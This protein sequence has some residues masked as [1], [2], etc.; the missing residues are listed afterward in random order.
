MPAKNDAATVAG[1]AGIAVAAEIKRNQVKIRI[2]FAG[3][4]REATVDIDSATG[5][6]VQMN[7]PM[8]PED[9]ALVTAIVK[10]V[11]DAK[12]TYPRAT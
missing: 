6:K 10:L 3:P 7:G 2:A 5:C 4:Y 12:E 1:G 9:M 8:Y 11:N